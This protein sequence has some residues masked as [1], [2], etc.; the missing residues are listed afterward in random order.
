MRKQ[1]RLLCASCLGV[2]PRSPGGKREA[3]S[4]DPHVIAAWLRLAA[5]VLLVVAELVIIASCIH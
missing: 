1:P 4:L 3:T 5:C 2:A